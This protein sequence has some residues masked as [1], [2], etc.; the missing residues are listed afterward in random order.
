MTVLEAG[1]KVADINNGLTNLL[2]SVNQVVR[3]PNLTNSLNSLH[4][5]LDEYRLLSET[6]RAK[7]DPLANGADITLKEAQATLVELRQSL[8]NVRDLLAPQA[9]LRRDVAV[10]MDELAEAARSIRALADFLNR[11]P[12]ALLSGRKRPEQKP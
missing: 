8:Q 12:N 11:N 7:V 6:V 5:T 3:S 4:R 9:P 2:V 10:T 1:L